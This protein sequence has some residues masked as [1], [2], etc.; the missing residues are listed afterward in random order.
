MNETLLSHLFVSSSFFFIITFISF[1]RETAIYFL[2][3]LVTILSGFFCGVE[4]YPQFHRSQRT[5]KEILL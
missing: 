2:Q 3:L 4:F 1:S 5:L